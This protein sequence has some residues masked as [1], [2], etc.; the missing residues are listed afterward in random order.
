MAK[1]QPDALTISRGELDLSKPFP[2]TLDYFPLG[3]RKQPTQTL[4]T[5]D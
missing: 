4:R 5:C 2:Y 3:A 1:F